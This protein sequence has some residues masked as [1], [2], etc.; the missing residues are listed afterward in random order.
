MPFRH[1]LLLTLLLPLRCAPSPPNVSV[2]AAKPA[3]RYTVVT[4]TAMVTDIVQHVAGAHADVH[5]LMGTG[6]DPHLFRPSTSDHAKLFGA[7]VIFYSGLML[8][9]GLEAVLKKARD[10]GKPAFAVTDDLD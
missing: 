1:L 2:P 4:T 9:G 10:R 5:G 8:E 7:D 6:V 3:A